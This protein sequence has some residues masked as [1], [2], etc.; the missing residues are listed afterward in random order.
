MIQMLINFDDFV[1]TR[2]TKADS[3]RMILHMIYTVT[4]DKDF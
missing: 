3:A 2:L 1:N 4:N